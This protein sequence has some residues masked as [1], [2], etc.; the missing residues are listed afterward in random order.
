MILNPDQRL[1]FYN[2][3][4]ILYDFFA[5]KIEMHYFC[6]MMNRRENI[7][8]ANFDAIIVL[9]IL[10]FT[11]LIFSNSSG[12][13]TEKNNKPVTAYLSVSNN[14]AVSSPF[15]RLQ[16]FPRTWISNRDNFNLLAFNRNPISDSKKICLKVS[17]LQIKQENSHKIP[18][19]ILLY[20]LF[21][22]ERDVPPLLS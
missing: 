17:Q 19:F 15:I 1:R 11:L 10:F 4:R 21:P 13:T 12:N 5:F 18:Q 20:Y 3:A 22:D 16:V 6:Q 8:L 7:R 2:A 14:N 9:A